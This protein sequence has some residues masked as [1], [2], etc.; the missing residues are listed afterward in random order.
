MHAQWKILL[1]D[2]F[3]HAYTH[4]FVA[5]CSDGVERRFYPRIFAYIADYPERR[6]A[7][8]KALNYRLT[9]FRRFS[10]K[11]RGA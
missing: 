10:S 9:V 3:V 7:F 5:M 2:K 6:V 4:G 11:A 1:D 8:L